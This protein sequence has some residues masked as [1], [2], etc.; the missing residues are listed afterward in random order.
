MRKIMA[1]EEGLNVSRNVFK[2]L[3]KEGKISEATDVQ[4]AAKEIRLAL[5]GKICPPCCKNFIDGFAA[6][7]RSLIIRKQTLPDR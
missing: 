2:N 7:C 5:L 6:G 3:R 1:F 4:E